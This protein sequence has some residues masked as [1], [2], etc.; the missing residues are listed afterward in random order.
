MIFMNQIGF[1]IIIVVSLASIIF[2]L[3]TPLIK[4]WIEQKK[5]KNY[6]KG[7]W[8]STNKIW[9]N[10]IILLSIPLLLYLILFFGSEYFK[11]P[12]F[13]GIIYGILCLLIIPV[14]V[15]ILFYA[16]PWRQELNGFSKKFLLIKYIRPLKNNKYGRIDFDKFSNIIIKLFKRNNIDCKL[17][18]DYKITGFFI[19]YFPEYNYKLNIQNPDSI[20]SREIKFVFV[21]ANK[22]KKPRPEKLMKIIDQYFE[23]TN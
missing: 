10:K 16:I 13:L 6:E 12:F 21:P 19:F 7:E 3:L 4:K 5:E 1:I 2:I 23:T 9:G 8:I 22:I 15:L 11:Y 14:Y 20:Y 18:Q 17:D